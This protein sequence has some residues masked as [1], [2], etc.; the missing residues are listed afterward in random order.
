MI[1][2]QSHKAVVEVLDP[3]LLGYLQ[4]G[5]QEV[6]KVTTGFQRHRTVLDRVGVGQGANQRI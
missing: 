1:H 5:P 6:D 3:R 4:Q 2:P